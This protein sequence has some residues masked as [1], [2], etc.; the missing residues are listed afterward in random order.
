MVVDPS[1]PM[2]VKKLRIFHM[3]AKPQPAF[4]V[5]RAAAKRYLLPYQ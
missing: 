1:N 5:R 3:G 2:V 4:L